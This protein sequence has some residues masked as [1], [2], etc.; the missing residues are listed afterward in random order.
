MLAN[1]YGSDFRQLGVT[2]YFY[3][4]D[5]NDGNGEPVGVEHGVGD[6]RVMVGM[7]K[8]FV[9]TKKSALSRFSDQE[10]NQNLRKIRNK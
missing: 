1:F 6:G 10:Q 2:E 9:V 5:S 4:D 8:A 7:T 3:Y